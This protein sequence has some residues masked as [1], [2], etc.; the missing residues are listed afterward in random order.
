MKYM[1]TFKYI[2]ILCLS[3]ALLPLSAW[4]EDWTNVDPMTWLPKPEEADAAKATTN[5]KRNLFETWHP[6]SFVPPDMW[7]QIT[8]DQEEMK[9]QTK[10]ILG[11]TAPELV[12]KIAPEIKPGKYTYQDLEKHPGLK[13]LFT[14]VILKTVKKGAPPFVCSIMDFDLQPT[15]QHHW[16]L[17][18]CQATKKN[19]GKAKLDTVGYIVPKTW[20]GGVPFPRPSGE[21]KAQQVYYNMEK[22]ASSWDG[23]SFLTGIGLALDKNLKVDK[24][25]KYFKKDIRWMGRSYMPPFGWFDARAEKRGEFKSYTVAIFE[26]RANRGL[27][28]MLYMYDD[29]RKPD[30]M[31]MYLPSMRR[32]RKFAATDTQDPN[33]DAAYD[34]MSFLSQKITPNKFPYKFEIIAEREYLLN[35]AYNSA[36]AWIDKENGY[37][38]RNV[39]LE[40]RPCYVLQMTQQDANYVYSKRIYYVDM[41]TFQPYWGEFYDQKG[42]LYREYNVSQNFFPECGMLAPYG[43]YAW[44]VDHIDTHSSFQLMTYIPARFTRDHFELKEMIKYGK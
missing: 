25:N 4:A 21:F 1:N 37:A 42:R 6:R 3:V 8:F 27:G 16:A 15:R 11:F 30:P 19:M 20:A 23:N 31:M 39:H 9:K 38:L 2:L 22:R 13:E 5:D 34:D 36:P 41:E 10:E 7:E 12:G 24:F 33:G 28:T 32:I 43:D 44:Q 40:R 26:P 14:P 35:V 29:P 18:V 17:S